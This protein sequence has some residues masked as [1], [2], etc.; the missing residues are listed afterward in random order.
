MLRAVRTLTFGVLP[1]L[2]LLACDTDSDRDANDAGGAE[3]DGG[4]QPPPPCTI[5][6]V[7]SCP[8][9]APRYADVA[10]IFKQRCASCHVANW[11]G[12]WPLDTYQHVADWADVVRD[13]VRTCTMPP[14]EAGMPLP[15][16]EAEQI[17][18]WIRCNT[19]R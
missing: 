7:T 17:L 15:N 14:P 18:T 2:A 3:L 5:E 9:P 6:A 1:W 12:P 10:P 4:G 8:E 16:E 11:S 19:P 13:M